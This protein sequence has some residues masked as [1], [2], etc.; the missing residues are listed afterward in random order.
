MDG[1]WRVGI[2]GCCRGNRVVSSC[3]VFLTGMIDYVAM[4]H[5]IVPRIK[6]LCLETDRL[7]VSKHL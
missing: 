4:K 7:A 3:R 5:S 1:I 2:G 6:R